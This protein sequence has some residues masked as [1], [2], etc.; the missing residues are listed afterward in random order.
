[1]AAAAAAPVAPTSGGAQRVSLVLR[2]GKI[3]GR[4]RWGLF[5]LQRV[6][7]RATRGEGAVVKQTLEGVKQGGG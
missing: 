4:E 7:R 5:A 3:R 6:R 2:V 1:M